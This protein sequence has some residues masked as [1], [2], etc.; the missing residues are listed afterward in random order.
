MSARKIAIRDVDGHI[1]IIEADEV[2]T[3][4]PTA[5]CIK[6]WATFASC[7]VTIGIGI[8]LMIYRD[9]STPYFFIGEGLLALAVGV[10]LPGPKYEHV[11]PKTVA[12]SRGNSPNPTPLPSPTRPDAD[13]DSDYVIDVR[14]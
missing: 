11:V 14:E 10:L 6:F 9:P 5:K 2:R 1:E 12:T 8:F 13:T 3:C 4:A 7:L